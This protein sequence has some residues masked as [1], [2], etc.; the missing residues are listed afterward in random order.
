MMELQVQDVVLYGIFTLVLGWLLLLIYRWTN[1][2]CN[3]RLPPGSM[4]LPIVGETLQLLKSSPSLDIPDFYKLRLKSRYGHLFKTSLVGKPVVVSMDMEFN[5]FVFR[6]NDKLFQTWYPDAMTSIFGKKTIS[7]CYGSIHKYIRSLGAPLYAPKNLKE[8]FLSE[9]E[10]IITESL[11]TWAANPTIEVKEAMTNMLFRIAI[12]KVIGF[13]SDSPSTKEL[14]KKFELFFQGV[15]SFPIY[16]PG[17]KFYQSMQARK[18]V[19]KVLK[20]LLKQRISTPQKRYGDFLDIVVEEL[21]SEEA[22]VDENFM[23]DLVCGL[24]FAG[25]ALT[26]TTLTIGMKFLTDSPNVVEALTE[27]HDAILKKREVVNSRITWEEFKYMKFTN[28]VINEMLRV[29]SHGPGILRKTLKDVHVN[30]YTI[31][32][33]WLVLVSPMAAHLNPLI[34]EDPLTFNPWRWQGAH[35][36][37]LMKN[38]MPFGDGARHCIGADF[39]KLQIAMFLHALVTKYRWKEI[40]G[41]QMFRI[42]DLVLPQPYHI[43]LSPRSS[44]ESE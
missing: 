24:I 39:T 23:V 22:L 29:S 8:A 36:S 35:G 4:G 6:N 26:P 21:Q 41:G 20:D 43:Q 15:V 13:E 31:P 12:K 40:K 37:S 14:R 34:F 17:T 44:S 38:F 3:G 27:E 1:P 11:R 32:E 5:R 42:S 33:G 16:V 28:Q 18:Y 9:M 2:A 7:E 30:G 19:Q 10:S 25:I